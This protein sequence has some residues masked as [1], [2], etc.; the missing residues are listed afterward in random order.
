MNN[1][2]FGLAMGLLVLVVAISCMLIGCMI[3]GAR[4]F[5]H[6]GIILIALWIGMII[7]VLARGDLDNRS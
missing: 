1:T 5:L 3:E 4:S 7:I 6:T 2:N